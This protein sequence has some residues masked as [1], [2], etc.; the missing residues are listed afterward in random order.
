MK[1][2][3]RY[4]M[5]WSNRELGERNEEGSWE[6]VFRELSKVI[7]VVKSTKVYKRGDSFALFRFEMS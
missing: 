4:I 1:M 6:V 5:T 3:Y 7:T 2:S